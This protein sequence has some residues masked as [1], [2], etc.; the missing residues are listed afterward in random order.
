LNWLIN[1][2]KEEDKK[3]AVQINE[4][5]VKAIITGNECDNEKKPDSTASADKGSSVSTND[6]LDLIDE[7]LTN[8]KER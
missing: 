2:S 5:I 7:V 6:V 1:I 8:K 4:V 3:M